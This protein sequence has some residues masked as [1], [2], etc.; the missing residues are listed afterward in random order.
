M[1]DNTAEKRALKTKKSGRKK[2]YPSGFK[3]VLSRVEV[4]WVLGVTVSICTL[5][6]T[7]KYSGAEDLR[8]KVYSPLNGDLDKM[9]ASVSANSMDNFFSG[10]VLSSLRQTG[11]F[12]RMPKFLQSEV[13]TLYDDEGQLQGNIGPIVELMEREV[14]QR[15]EAVR[16]EQGDRQWLLEAS[17]R[18]LAEERRSQEPLFSTVSR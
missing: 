6:L 12:Y 10:N 1:L 16:S 18:I 13:S 15:A 2:G 17:A 9:P 8:N 7:Y 4:K 14:S 5:F 11:D 3:N